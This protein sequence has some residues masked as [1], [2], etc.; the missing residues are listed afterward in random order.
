M[1]LGPGQWPR[2]QPEAPAPHHAP[3]LAFQLARTQVPGQCIAKLKIHLALYL[4]LLLSLIHICRNTHLHGG[5]QKKD[6]DY[7]HNLQPT[8]LHFPNRPKIAKYPQLFKDM[9]LAGSTC[10]S[11]SVA[12]CPT[13][14]QPFKDIQWPPPLPGGAVHFPRPSWSHLSPWSVEH[15]P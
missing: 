6:E 8:P 1:D 3:S 14:P 5:T 10:L 11:A 7:G 2:P 4:P 12:F 9:H 13:A 15:V